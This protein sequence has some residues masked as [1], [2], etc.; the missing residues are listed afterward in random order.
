MQFGLAS[1]I[2]VSVELSLKKLPMIAYWYA[3]SAIKEP[4]IV[5]QLTVSLIIVEVNTFAVLFVGYGLAKLYGAFEEF[6]P[7]LLE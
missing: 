1:K 7:I 2:K 6:T 3:E 5:F 4:L